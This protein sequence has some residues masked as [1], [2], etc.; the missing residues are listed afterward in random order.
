MFAVNEVPCDRC[1]G[2][3]GF[4]VEAG[5]HCGHPGALVYTCGRCG[6]VI[7]IKRGGQQQQQPKKPNS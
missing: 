3:A 4:Q 2:T 1:G 7:W 6:H 5:P